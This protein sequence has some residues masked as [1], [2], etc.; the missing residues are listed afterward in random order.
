MVATLLSLRY[1]LANTIDT[2]IGLTFVLDG[3]NFLA[4]SEYL[5]N[6]TEIFETIVYPLFLTTK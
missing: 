1:W 5:L 2:Y 4:C 3:G 6:L